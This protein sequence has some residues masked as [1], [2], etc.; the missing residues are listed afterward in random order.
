ML[1]ENQKKKKA[2]AAKLSIVSN[3]SLVVLK[4]LAGVLSGSVG[5]ISDAIH[6]GIDLG[7]SVVAYFSIKIADSPAD[8]D[9]KYGHGKYEDISGLAEGILIILVSLIILNEAVSRFINLDAFEIQED[10]AIAILV[11]SAVINFLVSRYMFSVAKE[12]D[13]MALFAD[14]RHLQTDIY[15]TIA[16]LIS[17]VLIKFTGF[18][19]LDPLA[20]LVVAGIIAHIGVSLMRSTIGNL[21]DVSLPKEEE[22]LIKEI[23]S[24]YSEEFVNLHHFKTRKSGV[25]RFIEFHLI[26]PEQITI[27][28]GHLL[29]DCLEDDINAAFKNAKVTIHLE[30]CPEDCDDCTYSKK[31][32]IICQKVTENSA[33][34]MVYKDINNK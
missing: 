2:F 34:A 7:T 21:V 4:L 6:S 23:I 9:H 25:T 10:F 33:T 29:C 16:V 30:P 18:T 31:D 14:A 8:D 24:K 5:V 3:S 12:T 22:D 26:I 11:F 1:S 20:G 15:T 17:L 19:W 27:K 32:T 28:Q 13:S